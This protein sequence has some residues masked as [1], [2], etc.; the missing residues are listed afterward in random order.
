MTLVKFFS[1]S[2]IAGAWP[3]DPK[4]YPTYILL[5]VSLMSLCIDLLHLGARY[6]GTAS[7]RKADFMASKIRYTVLVIQAIAS[8]TGTGVFNGTKAAGSAQDLFGWTC[9]PAADQFANVNSSD[10]V[11]NSNVSPL[12]YTLYLILR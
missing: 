1:T 7:A 8:A 5:I 10:L 11:C 6:C 12:H 2:H 3:T 9:S 4:L